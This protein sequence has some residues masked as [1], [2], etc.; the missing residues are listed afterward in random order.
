[1][2]AF[3]INLR[4][5]EDK[6]FHLQK[7]IA[8]TNLQ[9]ERFDALRGSTTFPD[10]SLR[11]R[12]LFA[13]KEKLCDVDIDSEGA[14]GAFRSHRALWKKVVDENETCMILEDDVEFT[15]FDFDS[16]IDCDILLL[17]LPW[18]KV[19]CWPGGKFRTWSVIAYIITPFAAS[20]LLRRSFVIDMPVDYFLHAASF[21]AG[22]SVHGGGRKVFHANK[23]QPDISHP[24]VKSTFNNFLILILIL[25]AVLVTKLANGN[26]GT[27]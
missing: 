25:L 8:K 23:F 14:V 24:S 12:S 27:F 17:G 22:L 11:A 5:R 9:W 16:E 21:D 20:E 4:E 13:R 26:F 2:K 10:L 3:I 18:G 15:F 19:D 7:N 6:F 1:M